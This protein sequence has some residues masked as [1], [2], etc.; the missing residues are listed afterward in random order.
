M[1]FE[2]FAL[3]KLGCE[4][5][6]DLFS[7]ILLTCLTVVQMVNPGAF[8][9]SRRAF[10]MS[11]KPA[12]AQGVESE[13]AADALSLIQRR[14]FR[15]FPPD[16]ADTDEPSAEH[17]A[18]VDDRAPDI[19]RELPDENLEKELYDAEVK[20]VKERGALIDFRKAVS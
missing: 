9:G 2:V 5:S 20:K 1:L 14:Y 6:V 4:Y 7:E 10:L 11:E 3:R 17:L 16:L 18:A 15:R 12:Y 19:E 8:W 13:C